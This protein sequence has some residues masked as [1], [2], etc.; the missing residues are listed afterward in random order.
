MNEPIAVEHPFA[1]SKREASVSALEFLQQAQRQAAELPSPRETLVEALPPKPRGS[2][3]LLVA[4]ALCAAFFAGSIATFAVSNRYQTVMV[5]NTCFRINGFT[6]QMW[7]LSRDG[8]KPV[9]E[10]E[11]INP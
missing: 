5:G 4:L 10:L 2:R 6:G 3:R 8:M 1:K 9:K 11:A 7:I